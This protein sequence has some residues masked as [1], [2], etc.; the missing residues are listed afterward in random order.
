MTKEEAIERVRLEVESKRG[1]AQRARERRASASMSRE[2]L[3]GIAR[4][5]DA[6]ATALEMLL[7]MVSK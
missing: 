4:E 1:K 3:E 2:S 7:N 6:D 5:Y